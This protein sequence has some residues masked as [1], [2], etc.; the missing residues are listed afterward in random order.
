MSLGSRWTSAEVSLAFHSR[1]PGAGHASHMLDRSG[2]FP[3]EEPGFSQ[4]LDV[5]SRT[6]DAAA[7]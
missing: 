5:I 2:H 4:M 1:P 3:V 6:R 7:N